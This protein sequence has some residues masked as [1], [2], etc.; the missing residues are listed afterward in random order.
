[1]I[2]SL[3]RIPFTPSQGVCTPSPNNVAAMTVHHHHHHHH[4][5][6]NGSQ[7]PVDQEINDAY[8]AGLAA[9]RANAL[10]RTSQH[11]L[12]PA[13]YNSPGRQL[14][15]HTS[16]MTPHGQGECVNSDDDDDANSIGGKK[17]D[18]RKSRVGNG[19]DEE[20][21]KQVALAICAAEGIHLTMEHD[22]PGE[23]VALGS[24][25]LTLDIPIQFAMCPANEFA[26]PKKGAPHPGKVIKLNA[27]QRRTLR[28]AQERAWKELEGLQ[29]GIESPVYAPVP[30]VYSPT[31][32]SYGVHPNAYADY[33][34]MMMHH[35]SS[36]PPSPTHVHGFGY[37]HVPMMAPLPG[38]AA[39]HHQQPP[40]MLSRFAQQQQQTQEH[41]YPGKKGRK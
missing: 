20:K 40:R 10:E 17:P 12:I 33:N 26:S 37:A 7:Q 34:M 1:M 4:V 16:A 23:L 3:D 29:Q 30:E 25:M 21:A 5:Y 11:A 27:R 22:I 39:H 9:G 15:V 38:G 31:C 6:A 28:R 2:E 41:P 14:S 8:L 19:I 36:I 24:L 32:M 18:E 35:A 13:V